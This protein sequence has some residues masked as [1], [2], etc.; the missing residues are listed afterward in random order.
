MVLICPK[1]TI[2]LHDKFY[3]T[4]TNLYKSFTYS[5]RGTQLGQ[6]FANDFD[7]V[8]LLRN[9]EVLKL[10][11][12]RILELHQAEVNYAIENPSNIVGQ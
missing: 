12:E 5:N 11:W 8:F 10:L 4:V 1:N 7:S 3:S 6:V 9:K 2:F